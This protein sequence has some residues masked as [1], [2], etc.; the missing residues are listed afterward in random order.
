[1]TPKVVPSV[2]HRRRGRWNPDTAHGSG[3]NDESRL[4]PLLALERML[5]AVVLAVV[6]LVLLTHPDTDWGGAARHLAEQAGLDP[7]RN[8]T[9]RLVSALSTFSGRQAWRAGAFALGYGLVEAVEGYG[10]LRRRSWAEYLTI[11][12]TAL[13]LVPEVMELLKHPT[14]LKIGGLILNILVVGYLVARVVQR[15]RQHSA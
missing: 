7:S 10:L 14:A 1:M 12:S 3:K 2:L 13:L 6:G 9:G 11:V 5:R 4:L 15:R 8:E